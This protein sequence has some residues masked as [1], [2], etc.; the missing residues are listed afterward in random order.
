MAYDRF[1]ESAKSMSCPWDEP[2]REGSG[3]ASSAGGGGKARTRVGLIVSSLNPVPVV[4]AESGER[5]LSKSGMGGTG[6]GGALK[7]RC[8]VDMLADE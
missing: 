5:R 4:I 6:G 2:R 3:R 7:A 1:G 8:G